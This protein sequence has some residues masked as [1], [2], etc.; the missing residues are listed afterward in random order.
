LVEAN[1]VSITTEERRIIDCTKVSD[2]PDTFGQSIL[3]SSS[4]VMARVQEIRFG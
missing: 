4:D 3:I 1:G 2:E